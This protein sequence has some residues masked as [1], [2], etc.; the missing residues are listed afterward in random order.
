MA[1]SRCSACDP[2]CKLVDP[3][4]PRQADILLIGEK[5][6]Q[7]E[8]RFGQVFVG[9]TGRELDRTYLPLAGLERR[10]CRIVNTVRCRLGG[11]NNKPTDAQVQA[12][13]SHWLPDEVARCQPSIIILMGSTACSLIEEIDLEKAHGIPFWH[14]NS[15]A[16]FGD[17][18][19]WIWPMYHPAAGLHQ[20][21]MMIQL[22]ED[23][24]RFRQWA[25]GKWQPPQPSLATDYRLIHSM[26]DLDYQLA[27]GTDYFY[28][29]I[30]TE[31][32]GTRP[33]SLQFSLRPGHGA[34]IMADNHRAIKAFASWLKDYG[35]LLHNATADLGPLESIGVDK[36][37]GIRD[38]MQE[39]YQLGNQ[40]Q[41]LKSAAFR[42]LGLRMR[43]WEDL[44]LP[45]SRA[46]MVS[47]LAQQWL[48]E[49]E[50]KIVV[51]VQLKRKLKYI[52]KPSVAERALKRILSHSH[53]VGYD[54]WEKAAE[55]GLAGFPIRSIA[56][57]PLGEAIE[58]ACRDA[59]ATG[60]LGTWLE[61]E[62]ARI[63]AGEWAVKDGDDGARASG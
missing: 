52:Y 19:G 7:Q 6:G 50:R 20:T 51:E 39:L 62:R 36:S 27:S 28:I 3:S 47:W 33:W 42:L 17:W 21:S 9:D 56:H 48:E 30:D 13:A 58:Y 2:R 45:P 38:T 24:R 26:E 10:N 37:R 25:M 18:Q 46:K 44:V 61:G 23:F 11:N 60:R 1:H 5:P 55:A 57:A 43:S 16:F 35:L 59:D 53:K 15:Y 40:P 12:C 4:G 29:P 14:S 34:M 8:A 32:D 41:A 22:I 63:V 54:L 31:S 49:S